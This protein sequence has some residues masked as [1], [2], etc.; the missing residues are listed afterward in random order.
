VSDSLE[1]SPN[2]PASTHAY[3]GYLG[4]PDALLDPR[5]ILLRFTPWR[6]TVMHVLPD[7]SRVFCKFRKGRSADAVREWH[8]LQRLRVP[9]VELPRPLF[10]ARRGATSVVGMAGVAGRALDALLA[11]RRGRWAAG[12]LMPAAL[13]SLHRQGWVYRDMY[14]N[15]VF[16]TF[17]A[18]TAPRPEA[19]PLAWIDVE[20]VFK[21]RWRMRRWVIKDLAGLSASV[22][23]GAAISRSDRLRFLRDYLGGLGP[24][25]KALAKAVARKAARIEAHVTRYPG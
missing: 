3:L 15:H 7:G 11:Q 1:L 16:A 8:A 9:G 14:W 20:R 12:V 19:P 22:P 25:W 18:A 10:L 23:S 4:A 24:G 2:L 13:R 5:G 21:P 6:R 17:D